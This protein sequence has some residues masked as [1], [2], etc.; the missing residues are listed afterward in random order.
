MTPDAVRALAGTGAR[1]RLGSTPWPRATSPDEDEALRV[2]SELAAADAGA[3]VGS[4]AGVGERH[5]PAARRAAGRI[6]HLLVLRHAFAI[7]TF[8]GH[9]RPWLGTLIPAAAPWGPRVGR[10]PREG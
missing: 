5:L 10:R 6:A 8:D 4:V 2:S 7:R 9:A 3:A 1:E